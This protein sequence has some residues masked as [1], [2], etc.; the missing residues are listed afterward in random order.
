MEWLR[1]TDYAHRGLHGLTD[2]C[3]ENS[4]AA[5]E[6]AIGRGFGIEID[7]QRTADFEAVVFHDTTLNRMTSRLGPVSN[8][9]CSDLTKTPL[10]DTEQTIPTLAQVLDLISGRVPL[11]VE[12]KSSPGGIPGVLEQ[13]VS[14]QLRRYKGPVAVMSMNPAPLKWLGFLAPGIP[15]GDVITKVHSSKPV[16]RLLKVTKRLKQSV[17]MQSGSG[18]DF[19]A[20]D[21]ELVQEEWAQRE[22]ENDRPVLT[23]TVTSAEDA[24]VAREHADALIFEGFRPDR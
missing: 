19:K 13:G 17:G 7:V 20:V 14:Q 8:W 3:P 15:R 12:I 16:T 24:Q 6:E 9:R 2:Q 18:S 4:L 11:L 22:R 5:V 21:F 1:Q 23:W 10:A